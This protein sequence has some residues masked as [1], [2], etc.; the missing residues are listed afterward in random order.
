MKI[1]SLSSSAQKNAI[2][3]TTTYINKILSSNY[4]AQ[5][6][7]DTITRFADF[8]ALDFDAEGRLTIKR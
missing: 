3:I 7:A 5:T 6:D 8:F 2:I 1:K 4:D